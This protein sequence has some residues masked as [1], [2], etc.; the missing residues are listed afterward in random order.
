[1]QCIDF[2]FGLGS[3]YSYLA[4]TQIDRIE[5]AYGCSIALH[6][7]S[8]V[9][10]FALRKASP[11]E[12]EP[13]SGQYD[14]EWRRRDAGRWADYYGVPFR[15]PAPL[16]DDHRLMARAC[17]AA[18]AQGNLRAF[19]A[20]LFRAVFVDHATIDDDVC[21]A[22]ADG[23]GM[24]QLRLAH[25]MKSAAVDERVSAAAREAKARGAFGVP[26][27]F[28]GEEMFW[29]NDRLP[30]LEHRLRRGSTG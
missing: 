25:N 12:G 5:G 6:P 26:T 18:E 27:F 29:G 24:D 20:A 10:L 16:P 30:L 7:I 28:V 14:W 1:M 11:F 23:L 3:R 21:A 15:E 19:T 4:F 2:Y 9:E 8:S 13:S 17:H 22:L